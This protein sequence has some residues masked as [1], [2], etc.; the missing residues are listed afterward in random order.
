[1]VLGLYQ[2]KPFL[3]DHELNFMSGSQRDVN[4]E[5]ASENMANV[6]KKVPP[7][8]GTLYHKPTAN[9]QPIFAPP[10]MAGKEILA[11]TVNTLVQG[12]STTSCS[13]KIDK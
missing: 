2:F 4:A 5:L 11:P 7:N 6:V 12:I 9:V 3:P 8:D 10:V 1:M 13:L